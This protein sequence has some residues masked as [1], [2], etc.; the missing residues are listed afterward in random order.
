MCGAVKYNILHLQK[1]IEE[2]R[3][4]LIQLG[5]SR[6]SFTDPDVINLSQKLDR[7]LNEYQK[8]QY[9]PNCTSFRESQCE[10]SRFCCIRS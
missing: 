9:N 4:D 5:N 6:K 2:M 8:L 10:T 1:F 7:L 3:Q